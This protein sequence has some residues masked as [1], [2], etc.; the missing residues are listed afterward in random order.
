MYMGYKLDYSMIR[1]AISDKNKLL[2][3]YYHFDDL[4]FIE[5][6]HC[7]EGLNQTIFLSYHIDNEIILSKEYE[8]FL[9]DE[10]VK[11]FVSELYDVMERFAKDLINNESNNKNDIYTKE[12]VRLMKFRSLFRND[13]IFLVK[14]KDIYLVSY[15]VNHSS[16]EKTIKTYFFNDRFKPV[17][18]FNF[19][20][21]DK[22]TDFKEMFLENLNLFLN[23]EKYDYKQYLNFLNEKENTNLEYTGTYP[24]KKAHS[25]LKNTLLELIS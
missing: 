24:F 16:N 20:F 12:Y 15:I 25:I 10:Q 23:K 8:F 6:S 17:F 18:M 7:L 9:T 14:K 2:I 21:K 4:H 3:G 13:V 1:K 5:I 22:R 19:L 11:A